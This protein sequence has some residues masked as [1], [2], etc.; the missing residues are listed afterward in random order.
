MRLHSSTD[1]PASKG[2]NRTMAR[3]AAQIWKCTSLSIERLDDEESGIVTFSVTGPL[4][5]RDMYCSLSPDAFRRLF[6]S[7]VGSHEPRVHHL[8]LSQVPYMDSSGLNMLL[9][10][11]L[12]CQERGVRVMVRG[13]NSRILEQLRI[14]SLEDLIELPPGSEERTQHN[15]VPHVKPTHL[16]SE[17]GS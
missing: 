14:S 17:L 3:I 9:S 12:R 1:I 10:H 8:D 11:S 15:L 4:T 6:E 7:P 16:G 13:A 2:A 5:A